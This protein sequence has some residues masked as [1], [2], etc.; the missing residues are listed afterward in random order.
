[1]ETRA[2]K[3]TRVTLAIWVPKGPKA[4]RV[5]SVLK[6][7]KASRAFKETRVTKATKVMSVREAQR[8]RLARMARKERKAPK[9]RPASTVPPEV[10]ES[11]ASKA[12]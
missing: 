11:L 9:D 4:C 5:K 12:P 8:E 1:M 7:P 6:G 10:K 3:E 2:I